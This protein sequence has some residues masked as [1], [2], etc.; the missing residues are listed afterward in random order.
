MKFFSVKSL[1]FYTGSIVF[2]V[3]L[4][5]ITTRYGDAYL[6]PAPTVTGRY[7]VTESSAPEL[8][9]QILEIAQSG[10]YINAT[11]IP[12]NQEKQSLSDD[13]MTNQHFLSGSRSK[14]EWSLAGR[15]IHG[16]CRVTAAAS[17]TPS[18]DLR[19]QT[20]AMTLPSSKTP[21]KNAKITGTVLCSDRPSQPMTFTA[22]LLFDTLKK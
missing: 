22:L 11:L 1:S 12:K 5:S 10:N 3:G 20:V 9:N 18:I 6:R 4:F 16:V 13:P 21:V 2:V 14:S 8:L 19:F 15:D 7:E 17:P